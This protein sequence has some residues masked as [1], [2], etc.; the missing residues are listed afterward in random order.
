MQI[1]PSTG[2]GHQT[3]GLVNNESNEENE[4]NL[5]AIYTR[6]GSVYSVANPLVKYKLGRAPGPDA[7]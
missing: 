6:H 1:I 4:S 3:L 2:S 7:I 5:E